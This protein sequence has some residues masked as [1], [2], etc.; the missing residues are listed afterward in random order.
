MHKYNPVENQIAFEIHKN[1]VLNFLKCF[2]LI[3]LYFS[4]YK[5]NR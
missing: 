3:F 4:L 1:D 5:I 2:L